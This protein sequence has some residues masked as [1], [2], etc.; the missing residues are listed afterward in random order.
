MLKLCLTFPK[1]NMIQ[2]NLFSVAETDAGF[3]PTPSKA[4]LATINFFSIALK[5]FG[6]RHVEKEKD[7]D[8]EIYRGGGHYDEEIGSG[9][10]QPVLV[11]GP[12]NKK[13]LGISSD[14]KII[15]KQ[16]DVLRV[17]KILKRKGVFWESGQRIK[18]LKG[19]CAG[20]HKKNVYA[21]LEYFL[22]EEFQGD[23]VGKQRSSDY[24][25][26]TC[27]CICFLS[28]FHLLCLAIDDT[29]WDCQFEKQSQKAPTRIDLL[30]AKQCQELEVDGALPADATVHAGLIPPGVFVAVLRPKSFGSSSASNDL[31]Q[32]I[33]KINL[34][35]SMEVNFRRTKNHQDVKHICSG[36]I[37]PSFCKGFHGLYVFSLGCKFPR[38][39]QEAG[40]YSFF[41]VVTFFLSTNFA[42]GSWDRV[43]S[44]FPIIPIEGLPVDVTKMKPFLSSDNLVYKP[45]NMEVIF[46]ASALPFWL[47]LM[48]QDVMIESN[49][50]GS[51]WPH[52]A[53]TLMIYLND[54]SVSISVE[55]QDALL[56]ICHLHV[57][58]LLEKQ[59]FIVL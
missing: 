39:F 40:I 18:V 45:T 3:N 17:H 41:S 43:S 47:F 44:C 7:V 33:L 56:Y 57:K 31:D 20:F 26:M 52:Y 29:D 34:E 54:E 11:V 24:M 55:C 13:A 27:L 14:G 23:F 59:I 19:A 28:F 58:A 37:T 22:I 12:L 53:A 21:T 9:E 50:M 48:L 1:N 4:D 6:S 10:D 46:Y 30:N 2:E 32:D 42:L 51:M 16:F 5:N 38:L 49:E 36:H 35:M 15:Y 25:Q 8:V